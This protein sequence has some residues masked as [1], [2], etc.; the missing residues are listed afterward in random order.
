[1][2]MSPEMKRMRRREDL[3]RFRAAPSVMMLGDEWKQ[4]LAGSWYNND[5]GRRQG[6]EAPPQQRK[7]I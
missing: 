5:G 6:W 7:V 4:E 3:G 1:M 2:V